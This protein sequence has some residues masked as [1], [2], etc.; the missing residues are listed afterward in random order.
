M[1]PKH[2]PMDKVARNMLWMMDGKLIMHLSSNEQGD[3][4]VDES[5]GV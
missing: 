1:V 3:Y 2:K 4:E 5:R